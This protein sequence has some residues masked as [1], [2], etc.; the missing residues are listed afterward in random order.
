VTK[1][2]RK[3]STWMYPLPVVLVSCEG[4]VGPNII[5]LA[6]AGVLCSDPVMVGLGI[7]PER[8]S[9]DIIKESGEFVINMPKASQ[10]ELVDHCG[11][12]SGRDHDKFQECG[13]TPIRGKKVKGPLIQECPVNLECKV[14]EVIPLGSHHLFIGEVVLVHYSKEYVING[15][16]DLDMA[17]PLAYGLSQYLSTAGLVGQHGDS[18]RRER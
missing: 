16:F 12:V 2:I 11:I 17:E 8:Y 14:H 18:V 1:I 3:P 7:R 10:V 4:S 13:F 6:W 15:R 5:T 9:Y